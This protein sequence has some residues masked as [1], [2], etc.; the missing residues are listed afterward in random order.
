M[1][2]PK[3]AMVTAW[4]ND[5]DNDEMTFAPLSWKRTYPSTSLGIT[6]TDSARFAHAP[7]ANKPFFMAVT[8]GAMKRVKAEEQ[9][10]KAIQQAGGSQG[11]APVVTPAAMPMSSKKGKGKP[12]NWCP[13]PKLPS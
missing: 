10:H 7:L 9:A 11:P 2:S 13:S 5:D 4:S 8:R 12:R 1:P 3:K 6:L